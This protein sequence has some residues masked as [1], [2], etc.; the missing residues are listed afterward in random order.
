M[1]E[2]SRDLFSPADHGALFGILTSIAADGIIVID[3]NARILL[4]NDACRKLFQYT[5]GEVL[6]RNV[7]V[8]MPEPYRSEHDSYIARYR[9]TGDA[10][11]IGIGREVRGLRKD[12]SE[13]PMYLSVGEGVIAGRRV[14]VGIVHD[15][16]KIR[17]EEEHR[18]Q[19]DRQLAQIVE[20]S[21]DA[22]ISKR[23]DGIV[24]TWNAGAERI[25]GYNHAEMIGRPISAI[26]PP[27]R[28]Q[29]ED[30]ILERVRGGESILHYETTRIR[31]DGREIAISLSVSPVRDGSGAVIG[32][33]KISRD[34]TER[35]R[36]EER[37]NALQAELAH[38]SRVSAVGQLSSALAHEL[39]QPLTAI[40]NYVSAAKMRLSEGAQGQSDKTVTLLDRAIGQAERA[41]TIIQRLRAFLEKR[42]PQRAGEELN[43]VLQEAIALGFVGSMEEGVKLVLDLAGDLP[44]VQVDKV[45]IQQVIVNLIRNATEAMRDSPVR[46][47]VISSYR[48][49]SGL[50]EISVADTGPG[51]SDAIAAQLFEAFVTTKEKGMG[52]GLSICRTIVEA[53]G[54]H[55]SA[56]PNQPNGTIFKIQ[57][58]VNS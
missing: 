27:E 23:L 3:E 36:A 46:E 14:F 42:E 2:K 51:I 17:A 48:A 1:T 28:Q 29:E 50:V 35:R 22:I 57:L 8:L 11:I 34:V 45:Q 55:I 18:A 6:S 25:F 20:S 13:F 54:G 30:A 4:Y 37:E 16:T 41:G 5:S 10:R 33:S 47:L 26:I 19:S 9:K 39:N 56:V 52:V 31:K 12:G 32:A 24:Q 43:T 40:M 58:P 53:H 21:D 15:L 38:V 49:G 7:N 44:P